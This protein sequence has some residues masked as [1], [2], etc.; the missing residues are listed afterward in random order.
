MV[1]M[2]DLSVLLCSSEATMHHVTLTCTDI[3]ECYRN[4]EDICINTIGSFV[5]QCLE[6]KTLATDS[7][8]CEGLINYLLHA[9][10]LRKEWIKHVRSP[11]KTVIYPPNNLRH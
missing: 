4:C 2:V 11:P 1:T 10:S 5:C 3:D 6:G 7:R 9:F 8:T